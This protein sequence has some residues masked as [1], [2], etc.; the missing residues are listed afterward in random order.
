MGSFSLVV[1]MQFEGLVEGPTSFVDTAAAVAAQGERIESGGLTANSAVRSSF[2]ESNRPP[3]RPTLFHGR[4]GQIIS[5][6]VQ[7]QPHPPDVA[8]TSSRS[9][10]PS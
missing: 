2:P 5:M 4:G 1:G 3:E 8:A 10:L 7:R 9:P 6:R